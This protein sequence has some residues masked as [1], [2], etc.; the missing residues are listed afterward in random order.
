[1]RYYYYNMKV[2]EA[3]RQFFECGKKIRDIAFSCNVDEYT[4]RMWIKGERNRRKEA[5][6]EVE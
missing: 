5:K 4:V 2:N 1:M 3:I 6:N